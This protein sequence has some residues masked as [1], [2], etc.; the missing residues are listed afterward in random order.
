MFCNNKY[1]Y[2]HLNNKIHIYI[3]KQVNKY[4]NGD[5]EEALQ[6]GQFLGDNNPDAVV[7]RVRQEAQAQRPIQ[8]R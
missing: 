8:V 5:Q 6:A 3:N 4:I 2:K 1:I 7:I